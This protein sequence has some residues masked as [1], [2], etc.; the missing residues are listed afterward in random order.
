[1]NKKQGNTQRLAV[2]AVLTAIVIILQAAV[3]IPLGPFTVTLTMLPIII[4]AI[5]YG[6]LGGAVLGTVFGVVVSIQVLTGAAGAFSTAML[7]YQ[8]AA[9]IL[10]CLLKGIAAGLAAGAFFRLFRKASFYLGVVMAAVIAPVVNTGIFS[11][12]CLT[13][14]RSLIQDALGTGSNLLLVFLTTFIGLN[15]LVEFGINVAL[16]P[17]VMRIFRAVK[18]EPA[19][20]VG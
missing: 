11:V 1:M 2:L 4:G 16:T 19:K 9:T 3:V 14:F 13:I 5:M 17:V 10:I 6:P 8:P 20:A 7:E 12:G 15:F 18:L